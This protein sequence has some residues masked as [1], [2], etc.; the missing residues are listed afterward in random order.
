MNSSNTYPK[1]NIVIILSRF[2]FPLE[3]GD[4]LRAFFQIKEL[5]QDYDITLITTTDVKVK[6]SDI[7]KLR[8]FCKTIHLFKLSKISIL[9]NVTLQFFTNKPFQIGYFYSSKIN[10]NIQKIIN[11]LK[12]EHIYCQLIRVSEYVKNYHLCPKTI[13]YM[14]ALSKGIE[15]RIE[16][17]PIYLKWFFRS[18]SKRLANYECKIFDY[19]EN[20]IIISEQDREY[21]LHPKRK[22][23]IC[24]PNGVDS[25]FFQ[26]YKSIKD[27]ELIFVGNLSYKPNIEAVHYIST[28]ILPYFEEKKISCHFLISG[29]S[30]HS[31]ITKLA[32]QKKNITL[33]GWVDDIKTSYKRGKIFIAPMMI[34]TGMQNKLL[35]A[36][37]LGIPCITTTL[38]N[39][40]INAVHLKSIIVADTENEFID[41]IESLLNDK[42]LY[43]TISIEGKKHIEIN[44]KW[45]ITTNIIKNIIQNA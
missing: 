37:A 20:H 13:D 42:K 7:Q 21:I 33:T 8:P 5:S 32:F 18:E 22:N 34:G 11:D 12:P 27:F 41:A 19:F 23:I 17:S 30:P 29:A 36:M 3:K 10:F 2:P 24:V 28:K 38:A 14:D 44:F 31:S 45:D 26:T 25:T 6:H 4:K 43:D 9:F 39:N 35:E 40:A 15:R 1:K 16:K